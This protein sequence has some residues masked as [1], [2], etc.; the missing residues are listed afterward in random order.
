[1]RGRKPKPTALRAIDGNAGHRPLNKNEP[2]PEGD[3]FAAPSHLT[4]SQKKIWDHAIDNAPRGLLRELDSNML[5]IWVVA[6]DLHQQAVHQVQQKGMIILT[7]TQGIEQ[8][9][10]YLQI[11]N[12]QAELMLRSA[13]ELGFSPTSR[14][15]ITLGESGSRKSTNR[16]KN[17][18]EKETA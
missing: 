10:P 6:S 14:T 1:M 12:K 17:H 9:S 3:L 7:P 16:F 8:Q 18:A 2:I 5:L 11:I 15:R 4:L 13:S